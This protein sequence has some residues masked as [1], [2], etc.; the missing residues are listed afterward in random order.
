MG[1][2]VDWPVKADIVVARDALRMRA[3]V[4]RDRAEDFR[5]G[6]PTGI[7][8]SRLVDEAKQVER[9]ATWLDRVLL[10]NSR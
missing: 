5:P 10:G 1:D 9:V 8:G 6:G 3:S 7:G 2:I 4:L